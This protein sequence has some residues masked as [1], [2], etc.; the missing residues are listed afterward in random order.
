VRPSR[1]LG[2]LATAA[3]L[4][5]AAPARGPREEAYRENNRGVA[6]LEQ[7][8][9]ADAAE[10]FRKALAL[11]ASLAVARANLAIALLNVPD[12][13]GAEREARQALAVLPKSP[14][15]QYVLGLAL[16][17]LNRTEEAKAAF[18][19]VLAIDPDDVGSHVNLG[20]LLL[21]DRA[22]DEA[23]A[24]FGAALAQEP[25]NG[26]ALYNLGL[27]LTRAGRADEGQ[28]T[29]ERFRALRDAGYGTFVGQNYPDQGRYAEAVASSG[30][31]A[32]LV[33]AAMPSVRFV[34]V[35]ARALGDRRSAAGGRVTLF[36][37]DGD[38]DL[39]AF[40]VGPAGQALLRNQGGHFE[41]V[42][43]GTG[44]EAGKGGVGAVAGDA[45]NDGRADLLVLRTTG[46]TLSR[47]D[48]QRGFVDVTIAA[49]LP[50]DTAATAAALAD[51]DHDGDLDVLLA[52]SGTPDRLLQ[53]DG[54]A[55]FKDVS[56]AAGF[57]EARARVV[58]AVATDYDNG[59]D[60]DLLEA[61]DDG[62][63]R[64]Y[65]NLRD[66]RFREVAG[67][68]SLSQVTKARCLAVGDVNKDG[69]TDAF[70]GADAGDLLA[71]SDGKG[72]F[73]V[74]P[75]PWGSAGTRAAQFID[76]DGDGL[77]DVLTLGERGARL[78][79]NLG[80]RWVDATL[81]AFGDLA[82]RLGGAT[83]ASGD[84]DGDGDTDLLLRLP[85][86]I[87]CL[88]NQGGDRK[89][90]ARVLLAGLVSNRGG[91]GA[92]IEMRAG[93]LRQKL[94]TYAAT[95]MP[96]PADV[97]FGLG[98][99][100]GADAIRVLWPAGILQTELAE[101]ASGPKAALFDIHELDRKPSSCPYLYAWNG[102]RFE[103]VTDF[104]GG[105]EIGYFMAPGVWNEPDPVEY[106][107]LTDE[108]LRPRDGRY[109]LRVTN[110]LEE[111]LFADH[112]ALMAVAH[113]ADV[114]VFPYEGMT[115]PP[116]PETLFAVRNA[117]LPIAAADDRG[118]DVLDRLAAMDRRYSDGFRLHRVRG[119][120]DPHA[121]TLD[122]G[123]VPQRAVLLLAGWTDYAFSSDNVAAQQAGL[124]MAP[125]S[126]EV[127]DGSGAWV[128]AVAQVGIPVGRPQTVVVDL[129]GIWKS[130]SRRVRIVTNMRIYW[131]QARVA[132]VVE[133]PLEPRTLEAGSATL[134]ERGF[135]AEASPDGRQPFGYDYERVSLASPWKAFPGRYTRA[136]DVGE[137]L[138]ASDDAFVIS[139]P[140]DE[141]ALGF[142]A[143]ALPALPPGWRRTFLL[144]ADGFSKEMDINSATPHA[145]APL[146][147]HGMSRYP[148][149][150]PETYPMTEARAALMER[151]NTR[152]VRGPIPILDAASIPVLTT[153]PK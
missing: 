67:D 8:R 62:P 146:P 76:Y 7:F 118:R 105:G 43:A 80:S 141:I 14:Q 125:P 25:H 129:T 49:G 149:E 35:T 34:D 93:S 20:Q 126:L 132:D 90:S 134:R 57:A 151:Y 92:K 33:D 119:Y 88:E 10:A 74:A 111:V 64:L 24:A 89:G 96:A 70:A 117:R 6:L 144:L 5:A 32:D 82:S 19:A 78:V 127:Q 81:A 113:P 47:N 16:R 104:M 17:G 59:R 102:R 73:A 136:G 50:A 11:D 30:A 58:A 97:V 85:G 148:Y 9:Q 91:V 52:G 153:R 15:G 140:G 135:S 100:G 61:A 31:E 72:R 137:L 99:R 39:D 107:R 36:D 95:P 87:R 79:R 12:L 38:G 121:L 108:Q 13:S 65:R 40:D 29:L 122:L 46:T 86:G 75:T 83:V 26:T 138:A 53:N 84:L 139:R 142:D 103:F 51:F 128:T 124:A 18:R 21:Q 147:F 63:L 42:T 152:V 4:L 71:L 116:K 109:E 130:A 44:L 98:G 37:Y 1:R 48:P 143:G 60:I 23:V 77:L 101:L 123:S 120:A 131:D 68:V 114:E 56:A 69:Y 106:V 2:L 115:E 112:M 41:D 54:T 94:E 22:Y 45:D 3:L 66:G 110:E 28:K 150:A 55:V 133:I 145:M 27:A